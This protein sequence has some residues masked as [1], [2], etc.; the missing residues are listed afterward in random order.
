MVEDLFVSDDREAH[1]IEAVEVSFG[2]GDGGKLMIAVSVVVENSLF[3][4]IT[5]GVDSVFV[6]VVTESAAT[7]LLL[8]GMENME[9]L[10]GAG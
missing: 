4:V 7:V 5:R 8:D 2:E 9:K 1:E 6:F 10:V 3:K